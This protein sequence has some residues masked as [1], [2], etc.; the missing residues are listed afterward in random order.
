MALGGKTECSHTHVTCTSYG[1]I[2]S[3][4]NTSPQLVQYFE[5][6]HVAITWLTDL[7]QVMWLSLRIVAIVW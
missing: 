5:N 3:T 7:L 6:E 4:C 2:T 1:N